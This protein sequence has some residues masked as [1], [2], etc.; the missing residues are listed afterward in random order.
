MR[1]HISKYP[2][3]FSPHSIAAT[4]LFW[5]EEDDIRVDNLAET[6]HDSF[7]GKFCVWYNSKRSQK[8]A[9]VIDNQ[10]TWNADVT[11][12][13]VI[14]PTLVKLKSLKEGSPCVEDSDV[15]IWLH[16][17]VVPP[18]TEYGTDGNHHNRWAYVLDEMIWAFAQIRDGCESEMA[19]FSD[20]NKKI[21]QYGLK[22]YH[23][24]V[25]N[26][27]RLFGKYYR[28]LWT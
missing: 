3:E 23:D 12:A 24:R 27:T 21:D 8:I 28:C 2:I 17:T 25:A 22:R 16:S 10:D 9:V 20:T 1:V 19:F 7:L 11:L 15:P 26:G 4:L 5:V 6:I 14:Y 18:E 13:H